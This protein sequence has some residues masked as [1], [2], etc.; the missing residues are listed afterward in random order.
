LVSLGKQRLAPCQRRVSEHTSWDRH[1][2]DEI[3]PHPE[4]GLGASTLLAHNSDYDIDGDLIYSPKTRDAVGVYH[5]GNDGTRI[6]WDAGYRALQQGVD[7]ALADTSN[8][9]LSFSRD[10]RRYVVYSISD[11]NPGVFFYGDRD[12]GSLFVFGEAY[13]E[14]SGSP[15]SGKQAVTYTAR[16][17]SL[18]KGI[19]RGRGASDP[20]RGP[21]SSC[22]MAAPRPGTTGCSIT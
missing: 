20:H 1:L 10:E 7:E 12:S 4:R 18:S 3:G 2:R 6:Y 13:P 14:L 15:L 9:L 5:R 8:F 19:S 11:V 16:A 17:A 22:P 21:R